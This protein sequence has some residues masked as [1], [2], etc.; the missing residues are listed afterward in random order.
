MAQL[1]LAIFLIVFGVN[2]LFGLGLPGWV[3]G[4][5]A[6]IAGVLLLAERFRVRVDR[7]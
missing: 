1:F 5:L 2:I 3:T 6:L 4:S 7:K